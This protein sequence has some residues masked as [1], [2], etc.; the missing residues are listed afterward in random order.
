[1]KQLLVLAISGFLILVTSCVK[2]DSG[3]PYG[4]NEKTG[5][6][7]DTPENRKYFLRFIEVDLQRELKEIGKEDKN[8]WSWGA[9]FN[10]MKKGQ[11]NP[12]F[13]IKYFHQRRRQLGLD[14]MPDIRF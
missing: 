2:I 12:Q 14:P 6:Y 10:S 7:P 5:K 11:E 8:K 13:Y 9:R 1:M 3:P 4:F